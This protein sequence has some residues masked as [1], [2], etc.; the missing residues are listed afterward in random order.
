[1]EEF[2]KQAGLFRE[3]PD[4]LIARLAVEAV[5]RRTAAGD[6][7]VR[8]GEEADSL[9]VVAE[10]EFEVY[11][12]DPVIGDEKVLRTLGAGE[13]FGEIAVF[14]EGMRTASVRSLGP[15]RLVQLDRSSCVAAVRKHPELGLALCRV[16]ARYIDENTSR[17]P[18]VRFG[19]LAEFPHAAELQNHLPKI[20]AQACRAIVLDQNGDRIVLGVVDP[21]DDGGLHFLRE[22]VSPLRP[23]FVVL[24][25]REVGSILQVGVPALGDGEGEEPDRAA[26]AIRGAGQEWSF[27]DTEVDRFLLS[28]LGWAVRLEASD[29]HLEPKRDRLQARL[30]VDGKL[31]RHT[32]QLEPLAGTR[33]V[34]RLKVLAGLDVIRRRVPQAGS[35]RLVGESSEYDI[36]LSILPTEEG[37]T[38]ALR[39][40]PVLR[41]GRHLRTLVV[42]PSVAMEVQSLFEQPSG[43]VLVAGP[44]GAGK[45]TTLYAGLQAAWDHEPTRNLVTVEDPI[46]MRLD[47]ATQVSVQTEGELSFGRIL[48]SVLRQDP[49]VIMVGEIR[50]RESAALALEAGT[51]GHLVLSS[52]HAHFA[53]ET[54]S[55][56]RSL[57]VA[58]YLIAS[59]LLAVVAQRLVPQNCPACQEDVELT[60]AERQ[61]LTACHVIG[62]D[63]EIQVRRGRG[64]PA[65]RQDGILGRVALFEVL[66]MSSKLRRMMHAGVSDAEME[67]Q[68]DRSSIRP[69]SGYA[70]YML[71]EGLVAPEAIIRAFPAAD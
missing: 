12:P 47:F 4:E 13:T 41:E 36:R 42:K 19:K 3:L 69:M 52:S 39:M 26:W 21:L 5:D 71:G 70:R 17:E 32:G 55:R 7:V 67:Q 22:A 57:G 51:T 61:A 6:E 18:L 16:L 27:E 1:M 59:G 35:F 62:Q 29:V 24:S 25:E 54:V 66:T 48:R 53:L 31:V 38:A 8:R 9:F 10:G 15:G 44:T 2:L 58:P 14:A 11:L 34:A 46:D 20:I 65:C 33:A 49:D 37:E 50:D 63:E 45:T 56:L 68:I 64:C 43:L 28:C 30:R 40:I 60:G 23:S